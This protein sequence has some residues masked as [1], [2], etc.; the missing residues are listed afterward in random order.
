MPDIIKVCAIADY[1]PDSISDS[2]TKDADTRR[3]VALA[4]MTAFDRELEQAVLDNI[5]ATAA[6]KRQNMPYR[7]HSPMIGAGQR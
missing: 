7:N 1:K 4:Y 5:L 6:A 2:V 3:T